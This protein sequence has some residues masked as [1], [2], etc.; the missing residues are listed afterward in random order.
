MKRKFIDTK[1]PLILGVSISAILVM[2]SSGKITQV[3][4]EISEVP[5]QT[6]IVTETSEIFTENIVTIN[7]AMSANNIPTQVSNMLN[8]Q[9]A[10][11][12]ETDSKGT[13]Y[14]VPN[15]EA[16]C[17]SQFKSYM[18]YTMVTHKSSDQYKLLNSEACYT[19]TENGL[20]MVGDRY[21]I[22]VGTGYC[23]EIGTWIDV[24]LEDGNVIKCILA[25]VKSDLHTDASHRYHSEDGSVAEF[26]VDSEVFNTVKDGSGSVNFIDGFDGKIVEIIVYS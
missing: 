17:K 21:C 8:A 25:D 23:A 19:N 6:M 5:N 2:C 20:R 16:G 26:V 10:E 24:I 14:K 18:R 7:R 15:N 4:A 22:A 13:S 11:N 1:L 12:I 3:S 9:T